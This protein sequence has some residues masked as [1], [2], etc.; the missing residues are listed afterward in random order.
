MNTLKQ[1]FNR[2]NGILAK[3]RYYLTAYVLKTI[4][5]VLFDSH[6][7]YARH[8]WGQTQ[9][10][11]FDMIQLAQNKALRI[12][13]FKQFM[14]P[15]E[16][17]YKQ[18]KI[19]SLKNNIILNNCPFTFD[20]LAN[21]LSDIF[22]Q[23]FKSFKEMHNRNTRGSQQY[24]LNVPKTNTQV[25]GSNSIKFKSITIGIKSYVESTSVQNSFLNTISSLNLLKVPLLL[26]CS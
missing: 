15:S 22:Y 3:L 21:N 7:R 23:F 1:K 2:A 20:K 9:S 13:N 24:L 26:Q 12:K 5:Y 4:Y 10:K 14:K 19:N 6:M 11:T 18:L 16:P 25:F 8:T 17:I